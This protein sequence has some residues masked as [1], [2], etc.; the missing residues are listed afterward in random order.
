MSD[1]LI[2]TRS[3]P[4]QQKEESTFPTETFELPS[5]GKFYPPN[6]PL[7]KGVVELRMMT[8]KEEDILT[9]PNLLKKGLAIDRLLESLIVDKNIKIEDLLTGDKNAVIFAVRRLAYGD[10]YG[11]LQIKCPKCD[12]ENNVEINLAK[13]QNQEKQ[14]EYFPDNNGHFTFELPFSKLIVKIK[15]LSG[16][17]EKE[18]ETELAALAKINKFNSSEITTRLKKSLVQIND[19]TDRKFINTYVDTQLLSRDSLALR[20]F[21]KKVTPD[22]DSTFNFVCTSCSHEERTAVPVTANFFWPDARV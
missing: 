18:I 7:S 10:T 11:P 19:K 21:I 22:I 2:I 1:E 4:I 13:I 5:G 20:Q 15:L 12:V 3:N 17:D 6:N 16:L 14:S 8:A 9:N